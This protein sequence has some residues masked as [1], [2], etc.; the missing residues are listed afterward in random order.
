MLL[1]RDIAIHIF[2][3]DNAMR[4]LGSITYAIHIAM[5]ALEI[6]LVGN[7]YYKAYKC[8]D[9]VLD[10]L[11]YQFLYKILYAIFILKLYLLGITPI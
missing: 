8:I 4:F 6:Q 5:I 7:R 3:A 11:Q 10:L 1:W 2:G 9:C